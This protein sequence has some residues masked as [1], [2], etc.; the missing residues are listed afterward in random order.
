MRRRALGF[1]LVENLVALAVLSIGLLG[2]AALTAGALAG[3]RVGMQRQ[4]AIVLTDDAASRLLG[5][6][7]IDE[8]VGD[9]EDWRA[10]VARRLPSGLGVI[11]REPHASLEANLDSFSIVVSWIE[12]GTGPQQHSSIVVLSQ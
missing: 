7:G 5:A 11:S 9:L 3:I 4:T 8:P 6:G 1:S 12:P 2:V 10:E